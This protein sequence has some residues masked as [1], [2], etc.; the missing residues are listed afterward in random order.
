MFVYAK[1]PKTAKMIPPSA[2][3]KESNKYGDGRYSEYTSRFGKYNVNK[4]YELFIVKIDLTNVT[5]V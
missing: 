3:E 1:P 5:D 4:E 2:N